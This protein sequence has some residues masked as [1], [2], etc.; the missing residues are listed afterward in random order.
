MASIS[1]YAMS[2]GVRMNVRKYCWTGGC[3]AAR[4]GSWI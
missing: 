4:A 3:V 2:M 1:D